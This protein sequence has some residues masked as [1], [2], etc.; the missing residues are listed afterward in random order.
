MELG[1]DLRWPLM[2]LL[3]L[4]VPLAVLVGLALRPGRRHRDT[5]WVA[6]SGVLRGLPRYAV[7]L[8][9]RRF[10][11]WWRAAAAL[12]VVLAAVWLAARPSAVTAQPPTERSRDIMLCLDSSTSMTDENVEVLAAFRELVDQLEGERIGLTIFNGAAVPVFPLTDD[13]DF[14]RDQLDLAEQKLSVEDPDYVAGTIL[15][16]GGSSL[17]ADGLVTCAQSFDR[18]ET[19]RGRAV[20]LASDNEQQGRTI[21]T[22]SE[23][24]RYAADR[25]IVVYGIGSPALRRNPDLREDFEEAVAPS[26]GTLTL[27]GQG[28][29]TGSIVDGIQRLERTRLQLPSR[30]VPHDQPAAPTAL[31]VV[32]IGLL[33]TGWVAEWVL[34]RRDRA[35]IGRVRP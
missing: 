14:I 3:L 27:L 20:V 34:A 22:M 12:L 26:G 7:L 16:Y 29:T 24:G 17:V 6:H 4:A 35:R 21:F 30:P 25:D 31:A 19:E 18:P 32:G 10:W 11:A 9:R 5:T 13:Y 2:W 1:A 8:R 23:A 15:M 33:A 28:Q